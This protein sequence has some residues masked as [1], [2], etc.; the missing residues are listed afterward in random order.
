MDTSLIPKLIT[1]LK[2]QFISLT[3]MIPRF[4]RH[5]VLSPHV[6]SEPYS[7]NNSCTHNSVC[8]VARTLIWVRMWPHTS[9]HQPKEVSFTGMDKRNNPFKKSHA[10]SKNKKE[11][12][13]TH[14]LLRSLGLF[15][16]VLIHQLFISMLYVY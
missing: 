8:H 14:M 3:H 12:K 16:I 15:L 4:W 10:S 6:H 11:K 13:G 9:I 1:E 2:E 5:H 7:G